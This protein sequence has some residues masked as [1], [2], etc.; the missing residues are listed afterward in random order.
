LF[1]ASGVIFM[2]RVAPLQRQ[3]HAFAEAGVQSG[4]FDYPAYHALA[5]RWETWGA[6]ALMTPVAGLVL[7]VFKPSWL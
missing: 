6:A 4:A 2:S 7:M 3:L 1:I 5:R